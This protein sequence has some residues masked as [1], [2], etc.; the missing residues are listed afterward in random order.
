MTNYSE[1]VSII[2]SGFTA[3]FAGFTALF[4][5]LVWW[6]ARKS[7]DPRFELLI[8][9]RSGNRLDGKLVLENM[10]NQTLTIERIKA[11]SP[12]GLRLPL[13]TIAYKQD[14]YGAH[15][16]P[17]PIETS[18]IDIT[19]HIEPRDTQKIDISMD[20]P[21]KPKLPNTVVISVQTS[22]PRRFLN[23]K[24]DS[25]KAVLPRNERIW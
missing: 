22:I 10:G 4:A 7:L 12:A 18:S 5:G 6:I 20:L 9:E 15:S 24:N 2:F 8:K 19:C 11:K 25:V 1:I 16:I 17:T 3:L 13:P 21:E 14:S 23:T